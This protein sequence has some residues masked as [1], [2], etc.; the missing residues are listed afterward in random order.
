MIRRVIQKMLGRWGYRVEKIRPGVENPIDV[1]SLVVEDYMS[2][3]G[4]NLTF[5]QV[6]ANDGWECDPIRKFVREHHWRGILIEPQ[7]NVF[8]RLVENYRDEP[9]LVFENTAVA[10][11]PGVA[12]LYR[13]RDDPSLPPWATGLARF[14]LESLRSNRNIPNIGKYIEEISVPTMTLRQIIAKHGL[15]CVDLLQ[16]DVEGYDFE[17]LKMVDFEGCR[18]GIIQYEYFHLSRDDQVGCRQFLIDRGY[19]LCSV[20]G[21]TIAVWGGGRE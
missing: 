17:V 21:D 7:P 14:N 6:G 12:T 10:R 19:R 13:L 4:T 8:A 18:P 9:Q 2:S 16:V 5:V 1:F 20:L 15:P 3:H 11:E